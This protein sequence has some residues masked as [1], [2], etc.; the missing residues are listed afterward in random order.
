MECVWKSQDTCGSWDSPSTP[1]T[2][3]IELGLSG[4]VANALTHLYILNLRTHAAFLEAEIS[5]KHSSQVAHNT[6]NSGFQGL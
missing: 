5:S 1:S 2:A 6:F 4:L 3:G